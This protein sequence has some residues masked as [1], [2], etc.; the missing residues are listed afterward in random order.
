VW[1]RPEGAAPHP[2]GQCVWE[3]PLPPCVGTHERAGTVGPGTKPPLRRGLCRKPSRRRRNM[4][5][6]ASPSCRLIFCLL[7]SAAVLRPGERGPRSSSR[8]ARAGSVFLGPGLRA[9]ARSGGGKGTAS[10]YRP[11][12]GHSHLCR[13]FGLGS[14]AQVWAAS[15]NIE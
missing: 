7:I 13:T 1:Q 2:R 4:A 6:K 10:E 5:S 15:R 8:L 9:Q 12:P 3:K 14:L 11:G